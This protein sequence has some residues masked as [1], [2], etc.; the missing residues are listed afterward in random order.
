MPVS[1]YKQKNITGLGEKI[2]CY[3]NGKKTNEGKNMKVNK[4]V[5]AEMP[6]PGGE[7][8]LS[9]WNH[10]MSNFLFPQDV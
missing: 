4:A 8:P 10:K 7:I 6:V 5:T 1:I 9:P 3:L 2:N